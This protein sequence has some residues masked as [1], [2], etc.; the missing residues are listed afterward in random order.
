MKPRRITWSSAL[1]PGSTG[2]KYDHEVKNL[3]ILDQPYH[4]QRFPMMNQCQTQRGH[5]ISKAASVRPHV[6]AI[7]GNFTN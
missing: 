4:M 1:A 5:A 7:I 6:R 2:V 3:I